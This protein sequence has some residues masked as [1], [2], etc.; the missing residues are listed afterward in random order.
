M[1]SNNMQSGE[2]QIQTDAVEALN[3]KTGKL[4]FLLLVSLGAII[5]L[6]IGV[7]ILIANQA[8]LLQARYIEQEPAV[9]QY[10][11]GYRDIDEPLY[12]KFALAMQQYAA[13][14]KDFQP[15]WDKYRPALTN[16]LVPAVAAPTPPQKA[17]PAK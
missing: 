12:R 6:S 16:L 17:Q 1:E 8:K 2:G 14:N 10:A 5:I 4:E 15:L 11:Q 13:T 3:R 9:K 7:N